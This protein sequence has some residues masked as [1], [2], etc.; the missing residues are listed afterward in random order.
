[1]SPIPPLSIGL[2]LFPR[3]TQLDLTGPYEIFARI[4]QASV[5]LIWKDRAPVSAD[6]GLGLMPSTTFDDCPDLD[7]ICVPGGPGQIDL[8]ADDQTLTFLRHKAAQ[9]RWITS[10]CTGSLVLGAA[11]LLRGYRATSHWSALDQLA[12]LGAEPVAERV[13][14]DRNRITGAGVTSGIDFALSVVA[15]IYG[16]E[17]AQ[18]IQLQMEYDPHPPFN[19]GSPRTAPVDITH[20]VQT[21]I[22]DFTAHRRQMT[23]QAAAR[24]DL[25]N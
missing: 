7:L 4:P 18:R 21:S 3:L 24:L 10:V 9:A 12:L 22:A 14:R 17:L 8:M 23:E 25:T 20:S 1:M 5:H 2:L 6:R 11:G 13:V 19:A 15:D 16:A